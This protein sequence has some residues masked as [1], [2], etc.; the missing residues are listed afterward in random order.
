VTSLVSSLDGTHRGLRRWLT[1]WWALQ[2]P[3]SPPL[4]GTPPVR[5]LLPSVRVTDH[6]RE[7]VGPDQIGPWVAMEL[8]AAKSDPRIADDATKPI[9][10]FGHAMREIGRARRAAIFGLRTMALLEVPDGGNTGSR[11][12]AWDRS[13]LARVEELGHFAWIN[14]CTLWSLH[15]ALDD[16]VERYAPSVAQVL[17]GLTVEQA[18]QRIEADHPERAAKVPNE[19]REW[20]VTALRGSWM[21]ANFK[22]ARLRGNGSERWEAP[23]RAV[24]IALPAIRPCRPAWK[25]PFGSSAPFEMCFPTGAVGSTRRRRGSGPTAVQS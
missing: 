4:G 15:S 14:A 21:K 2:L 22:I 7:R 16:L 23:L 24:G 25:W 3:L 1:Q 19:V 18:M 17:S 5:K 9:A 20:I 13:E 10:D 6:V 11:Q 12:A 8:E